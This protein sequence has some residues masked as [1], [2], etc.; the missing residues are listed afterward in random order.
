MP[1]LQIIS[2]GFALRTGTQCFNNFHQVKMY[3]IKLHEFLVIV[4][5][6]K[7]LVIP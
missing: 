4:I 3:Y 2:F 5:Y 1:R 7:Y 6:V